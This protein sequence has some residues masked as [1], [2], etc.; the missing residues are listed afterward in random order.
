MTK[1]KKI[2]ATKGGKFDAPDGGVRVIEPGDQL[3]GRLALAAIENGWGEYA[4]AEKPADK[5]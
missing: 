5:D 3:S 4:N 2:V 1:S